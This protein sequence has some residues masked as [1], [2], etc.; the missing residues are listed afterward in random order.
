MPFPGGIARSGS[1]VGSRYS[2]LPAS[3]NDALCPTLRGQVEHTDVP[4]DVEAVFEIVI[5]GLALEPV[6]EAMRVGLVRRRRGGRQPRDRRQL[7]RQP[8]PVPHPSARADAMTLTLTLRE[9]P[10]VP[11][12]AEVLYARPARRRARGRSRRCRCGTATSARGWASSSRSPGSGDDVRLEGDLRR[13]RFVGAGMTRGRL[14]V[15]G[16][17]GDARRGRACAAASCT[18]RATPATGPARGCAAG[19]LVVRGSAGRRLGGV[20]PGE[21][22]GMRGG[23]IVVHGDAG[24]QAGAGLRRGLIAVGRARRRGRRAAHAGGDDRRA[25]RARRRGRAPG[26]RRGSIVTMAPATPL[27][28]FAFSCRLPPA[29]P[30]P[31]PAPAARARAGRLRRAA[32]RPLRAL[33]RRRA[34]AAARRDPDPGRTT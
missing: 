18:S 12:E 13:V 34:R 29:V 14:T 17:V 22:A 8:R 26:M 2:A 16:D 15:A 1:K 21:R 30:A 31:V 19:T 33:V 28:T 23:E 7:R 3:T 25:R 10:D 6:R 5:D 4:P 11:L 20:H 24:E 27:S 32:R 9:Q